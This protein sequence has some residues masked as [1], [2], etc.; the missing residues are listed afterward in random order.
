M[1]A[2]VL[3]GMDKTQELVSLDARNSRVEPGCEPK[4]LGKMRIRS[5]IHERQRSG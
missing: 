3:A 5:T 2:L 1:V 4:Q